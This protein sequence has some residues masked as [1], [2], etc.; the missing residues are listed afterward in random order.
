[1]ENS[2][3]LELGKAGKK[4]DRSGQSGQPCPEETSWRLLPWVQAQGTPKLSQVCNEVV[5]HL[6]S[7]YRCAP[8]GRQPD[9]THSVCTPGK[10]SSPLLPAWMKYA[11]LPSC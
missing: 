2:K 6:Q 11:R 7:F 4:T 3:T 9:K 8:A 10:V 1:M 5:V